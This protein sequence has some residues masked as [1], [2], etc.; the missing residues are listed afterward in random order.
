MEIIKKAELNFGTLYYFNDY[1]SKNR[2]TDFSIS[3]DARK[4]REAVWKFKDGRP[5]RD[6]WQLMSVLADWIKENI[7]AETGEWGFIPCPTSCEQTYR[8]RYS[9]LLNML[10]ARM[11]KLH[12]LN[13][14]IRY[15]GHKVP[16][17]LGGART[18]VEAGI[19]RFTAPADCKNIIVFDDLV[20]SGKTM[21]Q[22]ANLLNICR[23][24]N[25]CF[26]SFGRTCTGNKL[27]KL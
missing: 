21:G 10:R 5:D 11:P 16:K 20:S 25:L 6:T 3:S 23:N 9:A 19:F 18:A 22:F 7:P 14:L 2:F 17:H 13:N 15:T 24:K 8:S 26:C 1:Y 27:Q 4:F 12:I